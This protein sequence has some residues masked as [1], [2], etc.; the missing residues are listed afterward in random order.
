MSD[1]NTLPQMIQKVVTAFK[2][3]NH[4]NYK[5]QGKWKSISTNDFGETIKKLSLGLKEIGLQP[6][7][8]FGILAEPSPHWIMID[9][10]VMICGGITVPMFSNIAEENLDFEISDSKTRFLYVA[11]GEGVWGAIQSSVKT[12]DKIITQNIQVSGS[13]IVSFE[14]VLKKGDDLLIREPELYRRLCDNVKGNDVATIIYTSGSTGT[15]KG[16]EITHKNLVSQIHGSAEIFPFVPGRD[17]TLSCLPLAH[18]FERMVMYY[19]VSTGCS[20]Y[21]ADDIKKVGELLREIKPTVITLVPRLLEKVYAKMADNVALSNGLKK[22][23]A[24]MAFEYALKKNPEK[25]SGFSYMVFDR[26]VYSKLRKA[27]GGNIRFAIAGGAAVPKD[28]GRFFVNIGLPLY[29]GYGLT[30]SSP[31]L[32]ANYEGNRKLGTVGKP[33]PGVEIRVGKGD[34]I[35]ARGPN[36]MRGYHNKPEAT[37]EVIDNDGWLHTGD[38]GKMD[39]DDYVTIT[40]RIKEMFKTSSGK[41]VSPI[42]VEQMLCKHKLI[43]MAA[44][45][46]EGRNFVTCLISPDIEKLQHY[47]KECGCGT[48]ENER[49]LNSVFVRREINALIDTVN[50]NLNNWEKVRKYRVVATPFSIEGGELTPTMK[51][52]RHLINMKYKEVIEEMYAEGKL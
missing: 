48:M 13:N 45:I 14:N 43:D 23:I 49:F 41:Y 3:P 15:P 26:M 28:I 36:I 5:H 20:I 38:M 33:F 4:F 18:V 31:V 51:V 2:N 25:H 16:V 47:K 50:I 42:P 17:K 8:G 22:K 29:E 52:R 37:R 39:E 40:G 11:G 21:F 10:A 27:L 24:I 9:L 30:E 19:Y 34:E 1:F 32:C 35:L 12:F 46:A 6:G 7:D 44:V